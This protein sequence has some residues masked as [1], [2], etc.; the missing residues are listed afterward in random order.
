MKSGWQPTDLQT[1]LY[2]IAGNVYL[3]YMRSPGRKLEE[4]PDN[5]VG[6]EDT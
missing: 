6:A 2:G 3:E 5:L 4:L 1:F